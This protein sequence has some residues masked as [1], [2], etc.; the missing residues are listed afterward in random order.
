MTD[1]EARATL[2]RWLELRRQWWISMGLDPDT[3]KI[4]RTLRG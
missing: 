2:E 3:D 4:L 1:E